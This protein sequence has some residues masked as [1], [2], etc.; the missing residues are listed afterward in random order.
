MKNV[1]FFAKYSSTYYTFSTSIHF[2]T[3]DTKNLK[4]NNNRNSKVNNTKML[5]VMLKC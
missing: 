4:V 5:K 1:S 2:G 3:G